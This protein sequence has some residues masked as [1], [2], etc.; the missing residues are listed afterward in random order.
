MFKNLKLFMHYSD[1]QKVL[2]TFWIWIFQVRDEQKDYKM[3]KLKII[4]QLSATVAHTY[5]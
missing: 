5:I 1:A 4:P 2:E 3:S